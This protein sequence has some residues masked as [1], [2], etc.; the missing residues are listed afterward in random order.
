MTTEELKE[1]KQSLIESRKNLLPKLEAAAGE[2]GERHEYVTKTLKKDDADYDERMKAFDDAF[3]AQKSLRKEITDIENV[4]EALTLPSVDFSEVQSS[5]K[6]LKLSPSIEGQLMTAVKSTEMPAGRPVKELARDV[7]EYM[8]RKG[9]NTSSALKSLARSRPTEVIGQGKTFTPALTFVVGV[10]GDGDILL[11]EDLSADSELSA[12]IEQYRKRKS[13]FTQHPMAGGWTAAGDSTGALY[14]PEGIFEGNTG[15]IFEYSI[16]RTLN[17]MPYAPMGIM[18]VLKF[19]NINGNNHHFI[20]Q[21]LRIN[22]AKALL[23]SITAPPA[24]YNQTKPVNEYGWTLFKT[25]VMTYAAT[26]IMSDEFQED[27]QSIADAIRDQLGIDVN[28]AFAQ[29]LATGVNTQAA[30]DI[31]GLFNLAGV[32]TRIHQGAASFTAP[33]TGTPSAS[34]AGDDVR[35][36]LE[37]SVLDLQRWGFS[38][39]YILMPYGIY[40]QMAFLLDNDNRKRYTDAELGTIRGAKVV[41]GTEV[42]ATK[43]MTGDFNMAV[44]GLNRTAL[45]IDI[46]YVN[47]QFVKDQFTLRARR[48]GGLKAMRPYGLEKITFA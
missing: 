15:G 37:R 8:I 47:D 36:T 39:D 25:Y 40:D 35:V 45:I 3:E 38:P 28:R 16:D 44:R 9:Y 31:T 34:L 14:N 33:L 19:Q 10:G 6:S 48:R 26:V 30:P 12:D 46:G 27:V 43:A 22:N 4:I 13:M 18:D 21:T 1:Y 32:N 29:S 41:M 24:N 42:P 2:L 20:R 5:I 23:E 7:Q 11:D 17:E